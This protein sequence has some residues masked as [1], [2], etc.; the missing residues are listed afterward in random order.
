MRFAECAKRLKPL[1]FSA[2]SGSQSIWICNRVTPTSCWYSANLVY[3]PDLSSRGEYFDI[4]GFAALPNSDC[5]EEQNLRLQ[6]HH[7]TIKFRSCRPVKE[8]ELL[9]T[10]ASINS[11]TAIS[12]SLTSDDPHDNIKLIANKIANSNVI[13]PIG[14]HVRYY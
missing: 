6:I 4:D 5:Y 1:L 10:V 11:A 13:K 14:V 3:K 8:C 2:T 12:D 9:D 7:I